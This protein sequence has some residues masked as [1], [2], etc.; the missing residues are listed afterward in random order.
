MI[1]T[2]VYIIVACS[3]CS[4]VRDCVSAMLAAAMSSSDVSVGEGS[5]VDV[6]VTVKCR[7]GADD[8]DSYEELV[9]V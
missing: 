4:Q 9:Q 5:D 2:H 7:L 8:K 1:R 3:S 6:P